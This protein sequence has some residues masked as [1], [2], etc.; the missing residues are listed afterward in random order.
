[1][2]KLWVLFTLIVCISVNYTAKG[3]V[4][5][6]LSSASFNVPGKSPFYETYLTVIGNS[7]NFVKKSNGKFQGTVDITVQFLQ[8]GE[9]KNAQKYSLNSPE[10]A[11]TTKNFPN[12][13]DQQRYIL[14]NGD[15]DLEI[16]IADKNKLEEKPL[17][18]KLSVNIHFPEN[19]INISGIQLLESYTKAVTPGLLTK[20]GYDLIPYVSTYFPENSSKLKFYA[21]IYNSKKIAGEGQKII[22]NYFIE[23][24]DTKT[25]LSDFT[26]FSK[27][28][29]ND[30]NILLGEFNIESLPGGNYNLVI[31]VRDKDNLLQA[32]QKCFIQRK[33]KATQANLEDLKAIDINKTFTANYKNADTLMGYMR[34]LR[35]IASSSEVEFLEHQLKEKNVELMQQFFYV[36]WKSR[37]PDNAEI[38]WLEYYKEVMKVNKEFGTYGLKGYDTDRG[39]VYLQYGAP[40]TRS[41]AE[42]EPSAYPY[43]IW[44]YNALVDK[45]QM[46]TNPYNT[47]T[48]KKFVFYNPDLVSNKYKL[49][50][51]TA[52]GEIYNSNWDMIL[53]KRDTQSSDFDVEKAPDHF[54][55]NANDTFRDP[56]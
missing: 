28:S 36:F 35:P 44:D 53:H 7:V 5:A 27:Q 23:T 51:S 13:L 16:T 31:E 15:Y 4:V 29:A 14:A 8:K 41:V 3:N 48:N 12:F 25:K 32:E 39:R 10:L 37:Y 40:S 11:D 1:M 49:L 30:V 17:L 19:V 26:A 24:F 46:L 52:K 56:R 43:E 38:S 6:Y 50:H 2:K 54:G 55:G 20:S 45:R 34:C 47:Q 42:N 22:L 21:E 18:T 9:V 33:N